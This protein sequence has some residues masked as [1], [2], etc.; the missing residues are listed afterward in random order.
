MIRR[1]PTSTQSRSS[2]ASDVYKRQLYVR[3]NKGVNIP[4][5]AV[6]HMEQNSSPATLYHFNRYKS[7]TISAS[8]S[9]G[10]TIGDGIKAMQ[11]IAPRVLDPSFQTALAGASRDY[12]ESSSNILFC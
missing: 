2:A 7:A 10:K 5:N 11:A 8:L 4:L 9:E 3:N 12:A 1:P 6:V